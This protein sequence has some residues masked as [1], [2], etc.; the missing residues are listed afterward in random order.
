GGPGGQAA[1]GSLP[2]RD[3]R[4]RGAGRAR[5]AGSGAPLRP[6]PPLVISEGAPTAPSESSPDDA[7]KARA[8]N[9]GQPR[10]WNFQ[11]QLEA[12]GSRRVLD[13]GSC[14]WTT[15]ARSGRFHASSG[16]GS[17]TCC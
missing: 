11:S 8:R 2:A 13:L 4:R 14:S 7:G 9:A 10:I 6:P 3:Q 5:G 15:A 16:G 12:A 17:P 1:E